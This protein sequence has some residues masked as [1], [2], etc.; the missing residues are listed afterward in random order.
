MLKKLAIGALATGIML[1]GAGGVMAAENT[2]ALSK[3]K[4]ID[5]Q[6]LSVAY[7]TVEV[8]NNKVYFAV[9]GLENPYNPSFYKRVVWTTNLNEPNNYNTLAVAPLP[10]Y[11]NPPEAYGQEFLSS[12]SQKVR[13]GG[14][15]YGQAL[16]LNDKWYPAGQATIK[17]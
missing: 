12:V 5:L 17:Y 3:E 2:P 13:S 10:D 4:V 9:K 7:T 6:T 8:R 15:V 16:A 1:S 14:T 11:N